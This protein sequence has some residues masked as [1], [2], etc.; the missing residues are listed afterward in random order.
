MS[1]QTMIEYGKVLT[2]VEEVK[3]DIV[4]GQGYIQ[5]GV[6]KYM[7]EWPDGSSRM[8]SEDVINQYFK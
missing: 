6:Q 3:Y 5:H 1:K 7:V 8:L 4:I 2:S